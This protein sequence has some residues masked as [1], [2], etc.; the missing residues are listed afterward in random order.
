[1]SPLH[2]R[3]N[4]RLLII[5]LSLCFIATFASTGV[6]ASS[7]DSNSLRGEP[8]IPQPRS[9]QYQGLLYLFADVIDFYYGVRLSILDFWLSAVENFFGMFG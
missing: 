5:T 4:P 3:M 7:N 6:I 8:I 9:L 1:M 2:F